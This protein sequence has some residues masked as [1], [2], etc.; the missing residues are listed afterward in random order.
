M[1]PA[2]ASTG[3]ATGLAWLVGRPRPEI[4]NAGA[5]GPVPADRQRVS[6]EPAPC[7]ALGFWSSGQEVMPERGLAALKLGE[8][9]LLCDSEQVT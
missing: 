3:N 5:H 9:Q 7:S 1:K 4:E 2:Q 8:F 6:S